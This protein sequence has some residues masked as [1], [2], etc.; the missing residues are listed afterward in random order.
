MARSVQP[1]EGGG[2]LDWEEV[3]MVVVVEEDVAA[4]ARYGFF[5]A[6][7]WQLLMARSSSALCCAKVIGQKKKEAR[8]H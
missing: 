5:R 8:S 6:T 7:D 2:R 3:E 4:I 1:R